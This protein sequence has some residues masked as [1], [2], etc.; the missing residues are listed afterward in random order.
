MTN[1]QPL[2]CAG[3]MPGQALGMPGLSL[4]MMCDNLS[5]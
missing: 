4:A 2:A 3:M 5:V 1:A